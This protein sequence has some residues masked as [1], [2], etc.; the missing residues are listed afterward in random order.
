MAFEAPDALVGGG[1]FTQDEWR[2][3]GVHVKAKEANGRCIHVGCT[4]KAVDGE[5]PTAK[6]V[7][8]GLYYKAERKSGYFCFCERHLDAAARAADD[9]AAGRPPLVAE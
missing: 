4:A 6:E 9:A 5:K 8:D 1:R 2:Q 7:V 3:R